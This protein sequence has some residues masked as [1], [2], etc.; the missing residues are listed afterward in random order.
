MRVAHASAA[1]SNADGHGGRLPMVTD[2]CH[3]RAVLPARQLAADRH[4]AV[5][6][7]RLKRRWRY[8]DRRTFLRRRFGLQTLCF[9]IA[10][11]R[12]NLGRNYENGQRTD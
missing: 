12:C 11:G 4:I 7:E 8:F 1:A 3:D 2:S 5:E 10:L 9:I 6:H